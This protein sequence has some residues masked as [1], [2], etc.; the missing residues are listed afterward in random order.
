MSFFDKG[1]AMGLTAL[2]DIPLFRGISTQA[3]EEMAE[4][5]RMHEERYRKDELILRAGTL[6]QSLG[7][8]LAGSVTIESNDAWG[9]R[10]ILGFA[11]K[12]EAFAETYALLPKEPLLVDVR[13]HE[14]CC[15]LFIRISLL[16]HY[17]EAQKLW[18]TQLSQNL[19]MN[20]AKKNLMLSRRS[21][22]IASKSVREKVMAYLNAESIKHKANMFE[23]PFNR[24]QLADYLN[25]ERT[26]LSKELSRMQADGYISYRKNRFTI[27]AKESVR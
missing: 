23:I 17:A 22:L 10:T 27:L 15:I 25:V 7:I 9:T 16:A 8:V 6:T 20:A 2:A 13:S 18:A 21:F 11:G 26:A 1:D 3:L 14:S 12:G 24:Q 19:L 5:L 4:A